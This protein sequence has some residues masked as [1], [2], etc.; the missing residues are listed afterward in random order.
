M[1]QIFED[2][3]HYERNMSQ[4]DSVETIIHDWWGDNA[5][6]AILDYE[7]TTGVKLSNKEYEK[8]DI[9]SN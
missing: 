5:N 9:T 6:N 2:F 1:K 8:F 4:D 3:C 7:K